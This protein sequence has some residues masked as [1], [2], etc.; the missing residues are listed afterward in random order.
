MCVCVGGGGG[1]GGGGGKGGGEG[2]GKGGGKGCQTYIDMFFV[3][4]DGNVNSGC[5][6]DPW[7]S[8]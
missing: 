6:C 5:K 7:V 8:G 1:G 3:M 4:L 2:G